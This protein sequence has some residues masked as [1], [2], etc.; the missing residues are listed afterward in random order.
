MNKQKEDLLSIMT[1][2]QLR[3]SWVLGGGDMVF[4]ELLRRARQV[5]EIRVALEELENSVSQVKLAGAIEKIR[6]ILKL[7]EVCIKE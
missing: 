6:L 3:A 5:S 1:V 7:E 2:D 4:N